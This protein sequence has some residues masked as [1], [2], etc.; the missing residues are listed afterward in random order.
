MVTFRLKKRKWALIRDTYSMSRSISVK[1]IE[2]FLFWRN[3]LATASKNVVIDYFKREGKS[4]YNSPGSYR[5][6]T[7]V[8]LLH[9]L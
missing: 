7:D 5:S 2:M 3:S 6:P 1:V 9:D 4:I 8:D